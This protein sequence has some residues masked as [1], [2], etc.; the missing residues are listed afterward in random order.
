LDG[1][2]YSVFTK[3]HPK[4]QT[5]GDLLYDKDNGLLVNLLS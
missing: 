4:N 1:F 2:R 3:L 5:I